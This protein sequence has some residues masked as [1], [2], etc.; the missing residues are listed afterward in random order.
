MC[1]LDSEIAW[2]EFC[3]LKRRSVDHK[4]IR[5]KVQCR[6]GFETSNVGSMTKLSLRV[7]ANDLPVINQ[8]HIVS[9]LGFGAKLLH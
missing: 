8:G 9:G 4:L 5:V 3:S 2:P 1:G 6:C 7:A